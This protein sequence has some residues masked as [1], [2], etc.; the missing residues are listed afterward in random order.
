MTEASGWPSR[1]E[2]HPDSR[3]LH[4]AMGYRKAF[5]VTPMTWQY[6]PRMMVPLVFIGTW[7]TLITCIPSSVY[8]VVVSDLL[9]SVL[10]QT[11]RDLARH[12]WIHVKERHETNPEHSKAELIGKVTAPNLILASAVALKHRLRFEPYAQHE[13]LE[14]LGP[15]QAGSGEASTLQRPLPRQIPRKLIKRS[16]K[17]M[18]NLPLENRTCM[19]AYLDAVSKIG[20]FSNGIQQSMDMANLALNEVLA[21]TERVLNTPL[22]IAYS[23]AISEIPWVYVIM[24]PF[25]LWAQLD[26]VTTPGTMFGAYIILGIAAIGREIENPFDRAEIDFPLDKFC[27]GLQ[28][29]INVIAA[30]VSPR[31]EHFVVTQEN[32]VMFERGYGSLAAKCMEGIRAGLR[33]GTNL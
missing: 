28:D 18:G 14:P 13:H 4:A 9:L 22:P 15:K 2:Q 20:Q 10:G 1:Q 17:N 21:G 19:S 29:A 23:I 24:L 33:A 32:T 16:K 26:W 30:R 3:L 11:S 31:M 5:E 7:A 8:P 25:Q 12:I 6:H 27:Q